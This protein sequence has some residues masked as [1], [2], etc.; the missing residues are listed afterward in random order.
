MQDTHLSDLKFS[1]L[2]LHPK[3]LEGIEDA[4]FEY[5]TPIQALALPLALEGKDVAG[6]AQTGTGKTAAFLLATMQRLILED[7]KKA[8]ELKTEAPAD[9]EETE[10][11][12]A[13]SDSDSEQS[14]D[15]SATSEKEKN[16][17]KGAGTKDLKAIRSLILAP[18]RELAIQIHKDAVQ[19]SKHTDLKLGLAY[20]G[21][22]YESQRAT[23]EAG[24]DIL[25]GTPGR[26]IDYF[27]QGVFHLNN[28]QVAVMDEAD[29]M[30]DLGFITDIRYLLRRMPEPKSRLNLLFSATLSFRVDELAYEHMNAPEPVKVESE[31]VV[32]RIE[33]VAYYPA[34]NEKISLLINLLKQGE[35]DRALVFINTKHEAAKIFDWLEANDLKAAILSGD[36]PQDRREK[37][38][39]RFHDGI[40]D[41]LVA[42][43][44][45]ARGLHIPNVSHVYNYDLPQEAE[46]Y[47]HRTGRTARAGA[48]GHAVSFICE[49]YAY[50][51]MDIEA[52]I[53]HALPVQ[54]ID[55]ALLVP[56]ENKPAFRERKPRDT[57][58][59]QGG[60]SQGGRSRPDDPS[61]SAG[62]PQRIEDS[63]PRK[64]RSES[65]ASPRRSYDDVDFQMDKPMVKP[66]VSPEDIEGS[67]FVAPPSK[68]SIRFGEIPAIG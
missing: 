14:E 30:F 24:V 51:M 18:T 60:K 55:E 12:E 2:N 52:F 17:Q 1:A 28:I 41:I 34:Q 48:S 6:Q 21:T 39:K 16:A 66:A 47:V 50:S 37:L 54:P 57:R 36:V 68:F 59:R 23:I 58:G 38:L 56:P 13:E 45:A 65:P 19:L 3:L 62:K 67:K 61:R 7:E 4:G 9:Q 63:S 20:G 46:D 43:D 29:R 32:Q 53:G 40:V 22:G 31:M 49:K 15:K 10:T 8:A 33:E 44:V 5:C 11:A 64:E 27:K 25:I 26:V 42:T 35:R